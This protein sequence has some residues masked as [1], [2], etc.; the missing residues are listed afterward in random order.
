MLAARH[1]P[2]PRFLLQVAV[3]GRIGVVLLNLLQT[4]AQGYRIPHRLHD[5]GALRCHLRAHAWPPDLFVVRR[6]GGPSPRLVAQSA[7][8]TAPE[9][10]AEPHA[11]QMRHWS[12]YMPSRVRPRSER[13]LLNLRSVSSRYGVLRRVVRLQLGSP[14][15]KL[16]VNSEWGPN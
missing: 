2:L 14:M 3:T 7:D 13:V 10:G 1:P 8:A 12:S 11:A 6:V 5:V 16:G 15:G 4:I 9:A